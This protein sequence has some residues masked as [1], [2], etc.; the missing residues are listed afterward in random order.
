MGLKKETDL[1]KKPMRPVEMYVPRQDDDWTNSAYE[2]L[3]G[4]QLL[5][6]RTTPGKRRI[7]CILIAFFSVF[8]IFSGFFLCIYMS[9]TTS[10]LWKSSSSFFYS[11]SF[12]VPVLFG[13]LLLLTGFT[14]IV[15][16]FRETSIGRALFLA[17]LIM[18][19]FATLTAGIFFC[20]T[21]F[22]VKSDKHILNFYWNE[23]V[24]H[25]FKEI[26]NIQELFQCSGF[27]SSHCCVS[28]LT[29]ETHKLSPC[30]LVANDGVTTLEPITF[31][32]VLWPQHECSTACDAS[33]IYKATC[34]E[35]LQKMILFWYPFIFG[36]L[37]AAGLLFAC[38]TAFV[39]HRSYASGREVYQFNYEY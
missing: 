13:C 7:P 29:K 6:S 12:L 5:Q 26:C 14:G 38:F 18:S 1:S 8:F 37:L 22:G 19:S 11:Y 36:G 4:D 3:N 33:N 28:N 27:H 16:A 21:Y 30:Y 32:R 20:L 2:R 31:Q 17:F 35:P 39:V 23:S 25:S 34:E 24:L 10:S 9:I 15:L